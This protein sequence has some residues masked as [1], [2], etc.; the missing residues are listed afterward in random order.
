MA[1]WW[2]DPI[3]VIAIFNC[4][5]E[6]IIEAYVVEKPGSP[7]TITDFVRWEVSPIT[8]LYQ[9]ILS[10][11][12]FCLQLLHSALDCDEPP[13]PLLHQGEVQ[14]HRFPIDL[15]QAAYSFYNVSTATPWVDLMGDALVSKQTINHLNKLVW[16][17]VG[18]LGVVIY[19]HWLLNFHW[20]LVHL[21]W[22]QVLAKRENFDVFNALDL[23]ENRCGGQLCIFASAFDWSLICP[24][25]VNFWRSWSL[26]LAM[27]TCSKYFSNFLLL[28]YATLVWYHINEYLKLICYC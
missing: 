16:N 12:S 19:L 26:A 27:A 10:H 15:L 25:S 18:R 20:Q 13:H 11:C 9:S 3:N 21:I 14:K 2:L 7:G 8:C 5:Q 6:N 4:H 28:F 1:A 17:W 23:M 24:F 22:W